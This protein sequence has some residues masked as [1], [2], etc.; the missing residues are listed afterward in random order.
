MARSLHKGP[1]VDPKLYK[2]VV[3]HAE[4]KSKTPIKTYSR[5]STVI[6]AMVG[7]TISVHNGKGWVNVYISEDLVGHRLGEFA[8][9]RIFR[10]HA[11]S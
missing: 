4:T 7:M 11:R 6:P 3:A 2:R 1:W 9:T 5:S 10:S 8:P